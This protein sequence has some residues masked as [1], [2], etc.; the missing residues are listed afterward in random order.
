MD[1][2]EAWIPN[3]FGSPF[4]LIGIVPIALDNKVVGY[5]VQQLFDVELFFGHIRTSMACRRLL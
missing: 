3:C 5:E 1:W 4:H 2:K